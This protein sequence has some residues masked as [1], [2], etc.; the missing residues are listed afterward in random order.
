MGG[1]EKIQR[2]HDA[3]RLTVRERLA[4]LLDAG[5]FQEIGGLAGTAAYHDD[6]ELASFT[7]ANFVAGA[8]RVAGLKIGGGGAVF[9]TRGAGAD[10]AIIGRKIYAEQLASRLRLPMVRLVEG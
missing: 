9:P 6:G 2:Q 7:A 8:A 10:A 1:P 5:S 3:G 4:A